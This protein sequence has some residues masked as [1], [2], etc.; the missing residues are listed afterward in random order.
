MPALPAEFT[1]RMRD[2][3]PAV[4]AG[5]TGIDEKQIAA[6]AR[7]L[8]DN[9]PALV[10]GE[11]AS[12]YVAALNLILGAPG[13][14]LVSRHEAPVPDAWKKVAPVADLASVSDGSL[15]VLLIDESASGLYIPWNQ[16]QPKLADKAVVVTFAWSKEGYGRQ[17]AFTLPTAVYPEIADDI[18]PA[19]DSPAAAFRLSAALVPPPDSVVNPADFIAGLAG[20]SAK[21]ALQER[22]AAILKAGR[23]SLFVPS[24]ATSTPARDIKPA[25][26]W[27]MLQAGAT[28]IDDMDAKAAAPKLAIAALPAETHISAF[29]LIV[30]VTE[31]RSAALVS[32][33][34]SKVYQES[35]LR[36]APGSVALH[37]SDARTNGLEAGSRARLETAR[38]WVAVN[39]TV[40][41]AVPPGL[42]QIAG[43]P[44]VRNLCSASLR[45]RVVKS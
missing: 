26:F 38:G 13:R 45:A 1:G 22:A 29:P 7:E 15:R 10:V 21:D 34:F 17:A 31:P 3:P 42:V 40:D 14:T 27:K 30:A 11:T 12:P 6:I 41:P 18:P 44:G 28:W 8:Q 20:I 36:L 5:L 24:S 9:G 33:L 37:P 4:V 32:P 25:D 23:G 35:N 2:Y 39:V 19:I 43:S 16:I